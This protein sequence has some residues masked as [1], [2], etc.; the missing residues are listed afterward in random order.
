MDKK[1]IKL[2][3]SGFGEWTC[4]HESS[5]GF[6]GCDDPAKYGFAVP[7]GKMR[8]QFCLAHALEW[9][10]KNNVEWPFPRPVKK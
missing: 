2:E 3:R 9:C 10:Y 4:S 8:T 7:K 6:G 5:D 1:L